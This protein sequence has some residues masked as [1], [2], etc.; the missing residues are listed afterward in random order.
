MQGKFIY[1]L[2]LFFKFHYL[3]STFFF[4]YSTFSTETTKKNSAEQKP[5]S[6]VIGITRVPVQLLVANQQVMSLSHC[7]L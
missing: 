6:K 2:K 3:I 1:I 5:Q 4:L 7:E